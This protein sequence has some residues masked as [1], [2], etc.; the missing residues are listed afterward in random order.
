VEEGI[1]R[2][3]MRRLAER[4]GYTAPTLYHYFGDKPGLIEALLEERFRRLYDRLRRVR[5]VDE[6]V[7]YLR[8]LARAFIRFGLRHPGHY[9]LLMTPRLAGDRPPQ[10]AERARALM[11][12]PIA[13]LESAGRLRVPDREAAAQV[14]WATTHGVISLLIHRPDY[15]WSPELPE[16]ALDALL[17]GL[18]V[19]GDP[20]RSAC[21]PEEER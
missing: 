3:S 21:A 4:C 7:D 9:R 8:A 2:F 11:E 18:V 17:T 14:L 15:D 19:A 6:P 1:E 20:A 5:R 12:V 16:L 13:E 10:S